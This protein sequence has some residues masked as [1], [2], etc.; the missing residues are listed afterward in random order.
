MKK[1]VISILLAV[2][3]CLN[4]LP[5]SVSAEERDTSLEE[6][7]A[8]DLKQM[9]LFKGVSDTDFALRRTPDR[10]EALVMLIR[11]L[12]KESEAMS[13]RWTHPFSD[14]PNWADKYVGY[15]YQTGLTN[16]VG[17]TLFGGSTAASGY[18]YLTFVLRALGYSDE[19]GL[20]FTWNDPYG[21]ALTT[22]ILPQGTDTTTFWRADVVRVSYAALPAKLKNS[23]KALYEKLIETGTFTREQYDA[24]Y[25]PEVFQRSV[26]LSAE[27]ISEA[28]APAV[29]YIDIYALN[30][31]WAGSGSGFFISPDGF[32]ITNF[33]VAANSSQLVITTMDGKTYDDVTILDGLEDRDL[34][35]LKVSGSDFPYL[36]LAD[37]SKVVQGQKV[38]ALG[39]PR[40]LEN[41]MS[42]GIISNPKR[43]LG[44]LEYIQTST[45]IA[46]GSSGGALLNEAGELVGITSAGFASPLGGDLNLA[47]P[48]ND[49]ALLDHTSTTSYV[50]WGDDYYPGFERAYDFGAF[51]GVKLLSQEE[52]PLGFISKYDAYDFHAIGDDKDDSD[53]YAEALYFYLS[54]MEDA[55]FTWT[56]HEDEL[57]MRFDRPTEKVYLF[58]D[59]LNTRMITVTA[60]LVPQYYA[61]FPYLPDLG[62]YMGGLTDDAYA[63]DES[64]MYSYEWSDLYSESEFQN[65]LKWYYQWLEDDGYRRVHVDSESGL[66]EGHGL[67]VVY[68]I[69]GP[70]I[71]VDVAPLQRNRDKAGIR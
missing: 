10:T 38:Y 64:L 1:R 60:E 27:Q 23:D 39:S 63:V 34:A 70:K 28:C 19:N 2:A 54:A 36:K 15:A 57:H 21:L 44:D 69:G 46:P 7:L 3:L 6:A 30:G 41:T 24:A 8:A 61:E 9:G 33:H 16:G 25:D 56:T 62:W 47:V 51:T 11:L 50:L 18:M 66:F 5:L 29:F 13:G 22:G 48:S 59:L 52:T 68:M 37:S 43:L 31:T 12:G 17:E 40:G 35:L 67:S 32:A 20:D 53:R 65:L 26:A 71:Y 45:P 55:G 14:V 49:I 42:E 4:V 58:T